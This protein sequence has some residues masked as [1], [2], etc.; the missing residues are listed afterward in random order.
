MAPLIAFG[1][2]AGQVPWAIA[3]EHVVLQRSVV[4]AGAAMD[5]ARLGELEVG[6]AAGEWI[7]STPYIPVY[8]P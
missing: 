6:A 5:S 2:P 8:F 3:D 1:W 4:R 7:V